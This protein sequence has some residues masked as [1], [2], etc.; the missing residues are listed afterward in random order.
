[1]HYTVLLTQHAGFL[2]AI[3]SPASA[4]AATSTTS[5]TS[6][7]ASLFP[8]PPSPA[9]SATDI[10]AAL[11]T[12]STLR[13]L[14]EQ[15]GHTDVVRLANVMKLRTLV[16]AD[17]WHAQPGPGGGGQSVAGC[18]IEVERVLGFDFSE[19]V[20]GIAQ[21]TIPVV[22]PSPFT[23]NLQTH[24]LIIAVLYY[25][26]IGS[27]AQSSARLKKLHEILD[28]NSAEENELGMDDGYFSVGCTFS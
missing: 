9:P 6:S 17:R 23:I 28:A 15:N 19:Q 21:S 1:M 8:P 25:T 3:V 14:A 10:Q 5:T 4:A 16:R 26:I 11:Q 22:P 24:A 18:L 2:S 7:D 27:S 12:L 13:S 20:A